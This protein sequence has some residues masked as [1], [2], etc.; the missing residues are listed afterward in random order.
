MKQRFTLRFDPADPAGPAIEIGR[1]IRETVSRAETQAL[2]I[3]AIGD[4]EIRAARD[5]QQPGAGT[6]AERLALAVTD[7]DLDAVLRTLGGRYA[8]AVVDKRKHRV[9]LA[10][11]RFARFPLC[12]AMEGHAVR[13]SDRAD[14][15]GRDA[16]D[17]Q[18][19]YDY[20]Y[21]H[22]IPAPRTVF[23]G[24]WRV[25]AGCVVRIADGEARTEQTWQPAFTGP[26]STDLR[27]LR[28]EFQALLEQAVRSAIP[29]EPIGCYLSGGTD[30]STVVGMASRV[31][32]QPVHTYSIGFDAQGYDEMSY[33]RIAARHFGA[34]HREYYVTPDDIVRSLPEVAAQF[35]QPFANSSALPGFHCASLAR[36][37]GLA[38]L[39]AGDGGDELFGGN[40]RYAKQQLFGA[41]ETIPAALRSALIEPILLRSP[42]G[43][44]PVV[45]K[46]ASY[47]RQANVPMPE[48]LQTYNLLRWLGASNVLTPAVIEAV[49]E[50][51]PERQQRD[52][53]SA[54][55]ARALVDRML[56]FDWKY[57]LADNDLP[58]V[59]GSAALA[60]IEVQFPLLD[61]RLVDFSLRLPA[62]Y[63]LRRFQLRWF[64]KEALKDFLPPEIIAKKKHGF[65]L[66][67]GTWL[68]RNDPLRRL[69]QEA[70]ASLKRR[71][72]VRSEFIDELLGARVA[73]HAKY[74]GELVWILATL[75]LW[76]QKHAPGFALS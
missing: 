73:E 55:Q 17:L 26:R 9:T 27:T 58:K 54:A 48:R 61:D 75:E 76:L 8:V 5:R 42:L 65:G 66:P 71:E 36:D 33:A 44:L 39:L 46:A 30:S 51:S 62:D 7:G 60:G 64:F 63:K 35:D 19:I 15:V 6:P 16:I 50:G 1:D 38:Y 49:V 34:I 20:L 69:S 67:F 41:Y 22:V 3:V 72:I 57:T 14:A 28:N 11:D 74:Y 2:T 32:G 31:L 4:P 40:T 59:V 23:D 45:R 24:A 18:A 21:F 70:L 12:Y 47:A 10:V 25:P 56:W 37:D 53:Y 13:V 68:A 29:K 52:R 43:R